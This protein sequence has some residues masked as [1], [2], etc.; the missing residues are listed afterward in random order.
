MGALHRTDVMLHFK[1]GCP[2]MFCKQR[3]T[4]SI[5]S[6]GNGLWRAMCARAPCVT[7]AN[8][9]AVGQPSLLARRSLLLAFV[10][11][12]NCVPA[13]LC[14]CKQLN[15]LSVFLTQP[16]FP[17]YSIF[18]YLLLCLFF[19]SFFNVFI[20]VEVEIYFRKA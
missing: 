19:F 1:P 9:I 5:G 20:K 3:K 14:E 13:C 8:V 11:K 6:H 2:S 15:S 7:S 12:N 4:L 18:F 10:D 17:S 16:V